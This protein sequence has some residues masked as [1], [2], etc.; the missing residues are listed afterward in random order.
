M[1]PSRAEVLET[2]SKHE[3]D[4]GFLEVWLDYVEDLDDALVRSL[5]KRLGGRLVVVFRRL[6]LKPIHMPLERRMEILKLLSGTPVLVDLELEGQEEEMAAIRELGLDIQIIAS[7][8]DYQST[9]SAPEVHSIL[10][11]MEQYNPA[12]Y[13]LATMCRTEADAVWLLEVLLELKAAGRRFIILGMGEAGV[14]TR[15]FGSMWGNELVFVPEVPEHASA[16]G[17]LTR[18]QMESIMRALKG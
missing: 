3:A 15:I 2:V 10:D 8:H 11:R 13:K 9:P 12:I 14:V 6:Q 5:A 18:S 1:R 4:Y 17:Q 16:P 7:H